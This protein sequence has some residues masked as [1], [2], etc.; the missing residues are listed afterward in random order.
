MP[1]HTPSNIPKY[2]SFTVTGTLTGSIAGSNPFGSE[3]F[4]QIGHSLAVLMVAL[5]GTM[6]VRIFA[7]REDRQP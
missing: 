6:L 7:R 3:P 4:F 5:L 2:V 1:T